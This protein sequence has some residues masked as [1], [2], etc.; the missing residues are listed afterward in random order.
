[1]VIHFTYRRLYIGI[2][3]S[4][5]KQRLAAFAFALS[6]CI[7]V[8]FLARLCFHVVALTSWFV[9]V[10]PQHIAQKLERKKTVS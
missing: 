5:A 10:A 9:G 7:H 6:C 3:V 4:T 8:R 2:D 1:M